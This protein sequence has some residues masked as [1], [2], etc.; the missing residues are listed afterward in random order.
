MGAYIMSKIIHLLRRNK[1]VDILFKRLFVIKLWKRNLQAKPIRREQA[2]ESIQQLNGRMP[3]KKHVFFVCVPQHK[4]M[5]DQAQR[6]CIREW[7]K[8]NYPKYEIFEI[9][10]WAFYEYDFR[11]KL[12]SIIEPQDF[13]VIQSGYC[14]TSTHFDHYVHRYIA[15]EYKNFPILVMPQTVNYLMDRDG[16]KTGKIYG[17]CSHML[18]LARDKV[19]YEFANKYFQKTKILLYPDIVT[20]LIG[21]M[22][23]EEKREGVLLCIRNDTEKKYTSAEIQSIQKRF[24]G[25]RIR[26]DLND[27]NTDAD[28]ESLV[29]E[30]DSELRKMLTSFASYKVV[31]TDRYHGTIFS[32]IANTPVVVLATLDHK[33]KTGTEWFK[34]IYDGMFYN[35]SDIEDAC[36][37]AEMLLNRMDERTNRTYFKETYYDRLAEIFNKIRRVE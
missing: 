12:V 11:R 5:G 35:A 21:T 32:M 36:I 22:H 8:L 31:I 15:K 28:T 19:S 3:G 27:T 18:F 20:S 34:G 37:I 6:Y 23:F 17:R 26:C 30:F 7:I 9:P 14:T 4:N 25:M 10:S 13:F 16:Y 24:S 2:K 29:Q 1:C 33:V